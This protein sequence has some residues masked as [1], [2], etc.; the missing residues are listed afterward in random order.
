MSGECFEHTCTCNCLFGG[1]TFSESLHDLQR[2]SAKSEL[3]IPLCGL[4]AQTCLSDGH[5]HARRCVRVSISRQALGL[6][7]DH[8]TEKLPAASKP[9]NASISSRASAYTCAL[10]RYSRH[11]FRCGL[12]TPSAFS[13]LFGEGDVADRTRREGKQYESFHPTPF[14]IRISIKAFG[15][16]PVDL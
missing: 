1:S 9:R 14:Q 11:I 8:G 7:N 13:V 10:I 15:C 2:D 6:I 3:R 5:L 16:L 4:F 12:R